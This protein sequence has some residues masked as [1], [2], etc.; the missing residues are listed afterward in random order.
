MTQFLKEINEFLEKNPNVGKDEWQV[1]CDLCIDHG[2][3]LEDVIKFQHEDYN[4]FIVTIKKTGFLF[5][6]ED[7]NLWVCTKYTVRK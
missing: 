5:V 4:L 6:K 3:N 7:K 2:A 1:L